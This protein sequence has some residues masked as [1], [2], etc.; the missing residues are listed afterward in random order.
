MII[1]LPPP[2]KALSCSCKKGTQS[3]CNYSTTTVALFYSY[4]SLAQYLEM[5]ISKHHVIFSKN[6]SHVVLGP[7]QRIDTLK[8]LSTSPC[9][10]LNWGNFGG[11]LH[12]YRAYLHTSDCCNDGPLHILSIYHG[13]W[14]YSLS[15][16]QIWWHLSQFHCIVNVIHG[17][18]SCYC[19]LEEPFNLSVWDGEEVHKWLWFVEVWAYLS[20]N[21]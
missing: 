3:V 16:E 11:V 4:Y 12:K 2:A 1:K 17:R 20:F 9:I 8:I 19:P 5:L 18:S 6:T 21:A 7:E 10:L 13:D 14:C 15:P